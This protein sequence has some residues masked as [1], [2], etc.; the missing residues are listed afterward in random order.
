MLVCTTI[1]E[2]GLDVV[3]RQHAD[4]RA[5]R[6]ARAVAA[7]P[8][9]RPGRARR[10]AGL[11]L[12]PLSAGEAAHRDRARP[13]GH[14]RPALRPRRRHGGGDEGPRDPRRRQPARRRAVRPH[15]RRRLRP[16]R[17]AGR[18]GG[19][20]VP[21][22]RR[23]VEEPEVKI[24]LPVDAHLPHEYVPERAAAAGDVQA[25]GRG[26]RSPEQVDEVRAELVDRYGTAAGAGRE[27]ARGRRPAGQGPRWR[28]SPTS[29]SRA[30]S[31]A[32]L[33]VDLADSLRVRLDRLYPKTVVK[34]ALRSMLG[35][36]ADG[37]HGPA[38]SRCAIVAVLDWAGQ[39][40][41]RHRG[42]G[43]H[44]REQIEARHRRERSRVVPAVASLA[45]VAA[46]GAERVRR[47]PAAGCCRRGPAHGDDIGAS[48][49]DRR[50]RRAT[51]DDLVSRRLQLHRARR[52][53]ASADAAAG[54]G[55]RPP[56]QRLD[57]LIA[58]QLM[59]RRCADD[60]GLTVRAADVEQADRPAARLP[61]DLSDDD[62]EL[63]DDF[64]DDSAR[65]ASSSRRCIGAQL[66]RL[67][68][69][70]TS[71]GVD[72]GRDRGL[73]SEYVAATTSK[74]RTSRSIPQY[75]TLGRQPASTSARARCPTRSRPP[76]QPPA[77][78]AEPNATSTTCRRQ[79]V[80]G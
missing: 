36:A 41:R 29:T 44:L 43:R 80:C 42:R 9:A 59:G 6:P 23:A 61:D 22:R 11:R 50:S 45:V 46:L 58:F 20:R 37:R 52:T 64:F 73:P 4:H 47:R 1:V 53:Q 56:V 76:R 54:R 65:G 33:P 34:P 27:P 79:Q 71:T 57:A 69:H 24:E 21:R 39:R 12:L 40:H 2:S 5:R 72:A 38:A 74:T 77:A 68:R 31:S 48:T 63:L 78:R 28:A 60:L 15:R 17:A 75:G 13:A 25:A 18:R 62:T 51:V 8:A 55:H 14:D 32:S 3:Q 35:A 16:L 49:D 7:A 66:R 70:Q 67:R 19:R 26:A 30:S 10:R